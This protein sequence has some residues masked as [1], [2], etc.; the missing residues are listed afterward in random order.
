MKLAILCNFGPSSTQIGGSEQVL[1]NISVRLIE[2]YGYEVNIYAFNYKKDSIYKTIN[3]IP[4]KKGNELLSQINS[5]DVV[6]TYSDSLWE[7]DTLLQNAKIIDCR[8]F[9][10]LVGAYHLQSNSHS[11]DLLKQSQNKFNFITHSSITPD[12]KWC[13]DNDLP[14]KVIPNGVDLS[15]F[16]EN[17]INFREKYKI[18]ETYIILS[19]FNMFY[20]K[21]FE[22][23]SKI[24]E[25]LSKELDDFI[26]LQISSTCQYPYDKIFFE[27][28]KKQC[29]NMNIRFFR[30]LPREDV[31]AA[32]NCSDVFLNVSKKEVA[33]IVILECRA[34][35][36]PYVSLRVGNIEE[37]MG[38]ISLPV[39]QTDKK[40]YAIIRKRDINHFVSAIVHLLKGVG[41]RGRMRQ[42]CIDEGQKDIEKLD[43]D[44]IVPLYHE[45]FL[46]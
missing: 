25:R 7:F 17:K 24:Y 29:K 33:P 27:R 32:F 8:A 20:G 26:I 45:M 34:A 42:V 40:G 19:V 1:E 22:V 9:C 4:C 2:K 23:L 46:K 36:L 10:A 43:W 30:D 21:G 41:E 35:K 37:Q 31:V 16:R 6:L 38:G 3:L 13:I 5:N 18:K 44:N 39:F 12:Y 15:E 14:L 11:F 28:T